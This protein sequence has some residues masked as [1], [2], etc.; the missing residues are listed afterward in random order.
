MSTWCCQNSVTQAAAPPPYL[1]LIGANPSPPGQ[2]QE[3]NPSGHPTCRGGNKST[4]ETQG[5]VWLRKKTQ[6]LPTGCT[7]CRLN[8]HN[9]LSRLCVYGIYKRLFRAPSK[10]NTSSDSCE[11]WRQEQ[12]GLESELPPQQVQRSIQCWRVS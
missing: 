11:H 4:I 7:S 12:T 9:Q 8:P 5:R 10:E 1:A 2:P 6:N 3:L